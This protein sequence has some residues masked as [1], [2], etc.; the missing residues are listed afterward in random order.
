MGAERMTCITE[1][2][3]RPSRPTGGRY[4]GGRRACDKSDSRVEVARCE[5]SQLGQDRDVL[6]ILGYP[7]YGFFLDSGASD[8]VS[9][10]NTY[11]L[12]TEYGWRGICVEPNSSF[13]N[14]LVK[15]R[16]AWCINCCLYDSEEAVDF[17]EAGPLG[18]VLDDYHPALL[19]HATPTDLLPRDAHGN[20]A[21]V[22]NH[23]GPYRRYW[24]NSGLRKSSTIGAWTPKAP[25]YASGKSFPFD[26]YRV[27]RSLLSTTGIRFE[28]RLGAS[29]KDMV[30]SSPWISASMT[31]TRSTTG[32]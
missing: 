11:L 2:P 28:W 6:R 9:A 24:H 1:P 7:R 17:V 25:S 3:T 26:L 8:G 12:E 27:R 5:Y 13:Y 14:A 23:H 20:P 29:C 32:C 30:T 10:S 21:T 16:V 15:N 19:A 18:G 4:H 31:A 22:L